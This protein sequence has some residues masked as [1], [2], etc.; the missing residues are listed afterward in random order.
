MHPED[1]RA[2]E[3]AA[4]TLRC[5]IGLGLRRHRCGD[6][7]V[8]PLDGF[9]W[10][11]DHRRQPSGSAFV[12]QAVREFQQI[13][14]AGRHYIDTACAVDLQID[15]A[16]NDVVLYLMQPL[17]NPHDAIVEAQITMIGGAAEFRARQYEPSKLTNGDALAALYRSY[18]PERG[19]VPSW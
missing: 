2:W 18:Q 14:D 10:R 16:G 19:R 9:E 13:V 6:V 4:A 12:R 15:K 1:G 5:A 11:R 17:L 3:T 8:N 7:R